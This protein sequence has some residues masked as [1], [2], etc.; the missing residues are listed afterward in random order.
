MA[1]RPRNTDEWLTV[2]ACAAEI[3]VSVDV[4]YDAVRRKELVASKPSKRIIRI[5]RS[6]FEA[7]LNEAESA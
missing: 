6:A 1:D 7:W 3:Q 2:Q 5:R 4:I